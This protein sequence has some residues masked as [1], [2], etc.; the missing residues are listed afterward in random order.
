[1]PTGL[2]AS[3]TISAV[4]FDDQELLAIGAMIKQHPRLGS[5]LGARTI[6]AQSVHRYGGIPIKVST[7]GEIQILFESSDNEGHSSDAE[8]T[9]M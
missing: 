4:I 5:Y 2:L 1:M 7:D 3:V 9:F 6:A 8:L